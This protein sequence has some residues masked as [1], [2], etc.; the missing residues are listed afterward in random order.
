MDLL[1]LFDLSQ[2]EL[3]NRPR[4]GWRKLVFLK[5]RETDEYTEFLDGVY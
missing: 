4:G 2:C 5:L 3:R 1:C